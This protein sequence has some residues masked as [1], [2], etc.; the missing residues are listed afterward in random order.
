MIRKRFLILLLFISVSV[1]GVIFVQNVQSQSS[2]LSPSPIVAKSVSSSRINLSW[3]DVSGETGYLIYRSLNSNFSN[4]TVRQVASNTSLFSDGG[5][6]GNTTYYYRVDACAAV[7]C[8]SSNSASATTAKVVEKSVRNIG[9]SGSVSSDTTAPVITNANPIS[10]CGFQ[11]SFTSQ[12]DGTYTMQVSQNSTFFPLET[13][14]IDATDASGKNISGSGSLNAFSNSI[15]AEYNPP[16]QSLFFT[17]DTLYYF[18]IQTAPSSGNAISAWSNVMSGTTK[19]LFA[20]GAPQNVQAT[21]NSATTRVAIK[22]QKGTVI[23]NDLFNN[24]GGFEIYRASSTDGGLHFGEFAKIDRI[25]AGQAQQDANGNYTY[26][27]LAGGSPVN[28]LAYEYYIRVY[29][30]DSGCVTTGSSPQM[31]FSQNSTPT[32]IIPSSPSELSANPVYTNAPE[33]DLLWKDNSGGNAKA[34]YFEVWRSFQNQTNYAVIANTTKNVTSYNDTNVQQGIYYYKARAC[35][36]DGAAC[37]DFSNEVNVQAPTNNLSFTAVLSSI[38]PASNSAVV[39]LSWLQYFSDKEVT[40]TRSANGGAA[41]TLSCN[42]QS[43]PNTGNMECTDTAPLGATF[44]YVLSLMRQNKLYSAS[45]DVNLAFTVSGVFSGE[46]WGA[47]NPM[48]NATSGIGWISLNSTGNISYN[49]WADSKGLIHGAAWASIADPSGKESYGWL[50]FN[51]DAN[52]NDLSGCPIPGTCSATWD[53]TTGKISG[54]A[55]FINVKNDVSAWDG[56]VSLRGAANDGTPYGTCFG[57]SAGINVAVPTGGTDKYYVGELCSGDWDKNTK[58]TGLAWAGPTVGGW[59]MWNP[60]YNK[61]T[62]VPI[63]FQINPPGPLSLAYF[64]QKQFSANK[65]ARW[66]VGPKSFINNVGAGDVLGGNNLLGTINPTSTQANVSTTYSAPKSTIEA[67]VLASSTQSDEVAYAQVNVVVPYALSCNSVFDGSGINIVWNSK[68]SDSNYSSYAPHSI[69]LF[70]STSTNPTTQICSS[71]TQGV[72]S[73]SCSQNNL[74]SSTT[75]Y[76][77]LGVNYTSPSSNF[78]TP[79]TSCITQSSS[80]TTDTPSKTRIYGNSANTIYLNWKD[81]ATTTQP[82]HFEVQRMKLTPQKDEDVKITDVLANKITLQWTNNTTS[83]PYDNYYERSTS[84]NSGIRFNKDP[85]NNPDESFFTSKTNNGGSDPDAAAP[86]KFTYDD[87]VQEATTY[88]YRLRA[89]SSLNNGDVSGYYAQDEYVVAGSIARPSPACGLYAEKTKTGI[90]I[91]TTTPPYAPTNLTAS[92]LSGSSIKLQW[93][94]NS[95]KETGFKIYQDG[96]LIDTISPRAGT[97]AVTYDVN[98]LSPNTSYTYIVK[99]YYD[100]GSGI[101]YSSPSND[102]GDTTYFNVNVA[103]NPSNGGSVTG[104]GILCPSTCSESY[105]SGTYITFNEQ[106]NSNYTFS[107]WSGKCTGGNSSCSFSVAPNT[108]DANVTAN[109]DLSVGTLTVFVGGSGS[110]T[111]SGTGGINCA[112]VGGVN[113]GKCSAFLDVPQQVTLTATPGATSTFSIWGGTCG[114]SASTTCAF[115]MV[116]SSDIKA[117]FATSSSQQSGRLLLKAPSSNFFANLFDS[118]GNI[119]LSIFDSYSKTISTSFSELQKT[120]SASWRRVGNALSELN[121]T[122]NQLGAIAGNFIAK[123]TNVAV[124]E[125]PIDAYFKKFKKN[126]NPPMYKDEGLEPDT[127]YIYRVRLVYDDGSGR[128]TAWDNLGAV[129]TLRDVGGGNTSDKKRPICTRNSYCDFSIEGFQSLPDLTL[130]PN[131]ESSQAQCNVNAKCRDVGRSGQTYEER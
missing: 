84:S 114:A 100:Y 107:S 55:R 46:G 6:V 77:K 27:D 99:A 10:A 92:A 118:V 20:P 16:S 45:A 123:N 91:A 67:R 17:P 124:G 24:Y 3:Q 85:K 89:C 126:V 106:P 76:Y 78:I 75:Y 12:V 119:G 18:R 72:G 101:V 21:W 64:E 38:A 80:K 131:Q 112:G 22:W 15:L 115:V 56:W 19:Q 74:A 23:N 9:G 30:S 63:I 103:V 53:T 109:F 2:L 51:N 71:E 48:S 98:G 61:P 42:P 108:G 44:T 94:D 4:A 47:Y 87:S 29:Q 39:K 13:L 28:G 43:N 40:I 120:I 33:I 11:I 5:L 93:V 125:D 14:S 97:G 121:K 113:T 60:E 73:G 130:N 129:K 128:F 36:T 68:Y 102:I 81:N 69:K 127:V 90:D 86:I 37:S 52:N 83:T 122:T 32:I 88:Y 54:W 65:A 35:R 34:D 104:S 8:A 116:A 95:N 1:I 57:A 117:T 111:V 26:E 105:P 96:T 82:Y 58:L 25:S 66:Y 50:S 59:I 31:V 79:I 62:T 7:G 110:G 49:V 70:G 41:V